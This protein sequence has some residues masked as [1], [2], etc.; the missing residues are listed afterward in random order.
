MKIDNTKEIFKRADLRQIIRNFILAEDY[1]YVAVD[2]LT[3]EE[4]LKESGTHITER[5]DA[6]YKDDDNVH[7]DVM[8]ELEEAVF[9]YRDVYLEIGMKAGARLLSQLLGKDD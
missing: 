1:D 9:A 6:L 5:I 4:R 2:N 7:S 8:L 3:Y